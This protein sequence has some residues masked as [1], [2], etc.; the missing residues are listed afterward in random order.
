MPRKKRYFR[1]NCFHHVMF[2]GVNGENLFLD[3]RDKAKF[4]L[5][6]QESS[7]KHG[8]TVHGFCLMS[9]H[10][11]LIL[12]PKNNLSNPAYTLL[13]FVMPNI[14]TVVIKGEGIFFKVRF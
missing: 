3:D 6:L 13:L 5:L 11:H 4:C 2:R 10:I 12:L 1:Q 8:L 7:E 14:L 9:N